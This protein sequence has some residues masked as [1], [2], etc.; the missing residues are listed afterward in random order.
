V[1]IFSVIS[2]REFFTTRMT[3]GTAFD[4]GNNRGWETQ[5][6][7]SGTKWTA[8]V[9]ICTHFKLVMGLIKLELIIFDLNEAQIPW[10]E[11][12]CSKS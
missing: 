8:S 9:Y 2:Y 7:S 11:R 1:H 5:M 10:Q 3:T 12:L 4:P 6:K